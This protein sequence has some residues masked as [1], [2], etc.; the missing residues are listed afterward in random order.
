M[1]T[2]A[3]PTP[4]KR[5]QSRLL[6]ATVVAADLLTSLA[7]YDAVFGALGMGRHSEFSDEEEHDASADAVG[8][9]STDG[10][11][12]L[13]LVVGTR[14]TTGAHIALAAL[15]RAQVDA[16]WQATTSAGGTTKQAPRGWEIYRP[17]YYGAI[18][19]DPD[20]NLVEAVA[21]E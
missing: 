19:A 1:T 11:A 9:G 16:F 2:P 10:D 17:G 12:L 20:G 4:S 6:H 5:P 7:F 3:R 21:S 14:P 8:F 13:W 15:D 18:V